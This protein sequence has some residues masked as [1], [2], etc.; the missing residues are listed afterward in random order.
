[1]ASKSQDI[2]DREMRSNQGYTK[3]NAKINIDKGLLSKHPRS[4]QLSFGNK[5]H[6]LKKQNN[7]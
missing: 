2:L 1:M 5:L 3:M 6:N 7:R 4:R